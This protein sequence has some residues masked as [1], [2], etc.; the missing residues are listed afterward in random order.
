MSK[1]LYPSLPLVTIVASRAVG[2]VFDGQDPNVMDQHSPPI[3]QANPLLGLY[4]GFSFDATFKLRMR[5]LYADRRDFFIEQ[6]QNVLGDLRSATQEPGVELR[7][8]A[9][10]AGRTSPRISVSPARS[11]SGVRYRPFGITAKAATG[12][13]LRF[14]GHGTRAKFDRASSKTQTRNLPSSKGDFKVVSPKKL[15][16]RSLETVHAL[17]CDIPVRLD[18]IYNDDVSIIRKSPI[19]CVVNTT[20]ERPMLDPGLV[21]SPSLFPTLPGPLDN[22][23]TGSIEPSARTTSF[24][25]LRWRRAFSIDRAVWDHRARYRI[26]SVVFGTLRTRCANASANQRAVIVTIVF[27][28]RNASAVFS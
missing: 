9:E 17:I 7:R 20:L 4:V 12:V 26:G 2:R 3:A 22:I 25:W 23:T 10:A 28:I 19:F 5:K 13:S 15:P 14:R 6:F 21:I 24:G 27:F 16:A 8:L 1:I 18:F 11:E